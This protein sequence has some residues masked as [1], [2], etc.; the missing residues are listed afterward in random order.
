[1]RMSMQDCICPTHLIRTR[2]L[3]IAHGARRVSF[4]RGAIFV[5]ESRSSAWA[6]RLRTCQVEIQLDVSNQSLTSVSRR[7]QWHSPS[8]AKTTSPA[9]TSSE[10]SM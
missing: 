10:S 9:L 5:L 4:H 8:P 6:V 1:M 7:C 3:R 2:P